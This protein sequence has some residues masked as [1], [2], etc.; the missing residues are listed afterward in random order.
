LLQT[1]ARRG[2]DR[3]ERRRISS[4]DASVKTSFRGSGAVQW[5]A[6]VK[7]KAPIRVLFVCCKIVI[8]KHVLL[9]LKKTSYKSVNSCHQ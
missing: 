5:S 1:T 6:S 8:H 2:R 9:P 7:Q 3:D 4:C